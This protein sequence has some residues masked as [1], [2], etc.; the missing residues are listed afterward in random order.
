MNPRC[1]SLRSQSALSAV[2]LDRFDLPLEMSERVGRI[3]VEQSPA[4]GPPV[5]PLIVKEGRR[6]AN[7]ADG[8]EPLHVAPLDR[9]KGEVEAGKRV[10]HSELEVPAEGDGTEPTAIDPPQPA[11]LPS[12]CAW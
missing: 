7:H 12:A 4:A 10:Q 3:H 11:R 9:P 2:G 8:F 6:V 5:P 1:R